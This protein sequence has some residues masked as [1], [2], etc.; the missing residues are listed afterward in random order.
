MIRRQSGH[1]VVVSSVTGQFGFPLRSAYSAAKHAIH[2]FYEALWAELHDQ[3]IDV[4]IICPGRIRTNISYH[5][6]TKNGESHG[7][8]DHGINEGLSA[9]QC[10]KRI[11]KAVK[12]KKIVANIGRKELL[13][14]YFK[15]Y[16]PWLFYKLVSKVQPT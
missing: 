8:M 4:T 11:V 9:E 7:V 1:I 15:R 14:V 3:G 5:A 16:L 6:L 12:R 2:G 13:M 10:A